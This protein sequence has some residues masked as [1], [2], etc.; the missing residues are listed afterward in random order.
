[1]E[2][3][4]FKAGFK[5]EVKKLTTFVVEIQILINRVGEFMWS[6]SQETLILMT[7]LENIVIRFALFLQFS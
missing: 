5:K 3:R 7:Q 1:M 4:P 2:L 6:L